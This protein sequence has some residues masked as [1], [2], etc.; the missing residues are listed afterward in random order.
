MRF[1]VHRWFHRFTV[2]FIAAISIYAQTAAVDP[3]TTRYYVTFLRPHPDRKP[4]NEDEAK[5]MQSSHMANI[6]SMAQQGVLVAAGPFEDTPRTMSGIFIFRVDSLEAA[7]RIAAND[8]TVTAN[9]NTVDVHAWQ[10]PSGIG[11]EYTRLHKQDPNTPENMQVHPFCMLLKGSAWETTNNRDSILREHRQYIASLRQQGRLG[12]AGPI[13]G[14]DDLA[15]LVIFKPIQDA[16][17]KRLMQDDPAVKA[18]LF[19]VEYH[20]WWCSGH[21]LPW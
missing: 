7:Q 3:A 11:E 16:E 1:M 14:S 19:R 5:R 17:A 9:R 12:A 18:G 8:P 6:R 4:L 21:V 10:G 15:G 2:V 13:E 20:R